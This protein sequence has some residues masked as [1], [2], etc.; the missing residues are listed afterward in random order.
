MHE[1]E[2]DVLATL[3]RSGAPYA[4]NPQKLVEALLLTSGAMTNRLDR[5]EEASGNGYVQSNQAHGLSPKQGF[6]ILPSCQR[7][8]AVAPQTL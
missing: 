6:R 1:G 7:I 5:L 8:L 2:F 4:L 3:Y